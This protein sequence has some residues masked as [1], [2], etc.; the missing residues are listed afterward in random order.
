LGTKA[1]RQCSIDW[2][3]L[4]YTP[5]DLSDLDAPF[6]SQEIRDAVFSLP[7]V[8]APGP[9]GFIGAFFKSC[10]EIIKADITA[11][12][13]HMSHLREGCVGLVN[14]ANIILIPKKTDAS[15]VGDFRPISLI[16]S[17]SKIFSKLLANR[18]A[19]ILPDIVSKCQS[20]FVKK[21][22]IHDNFLHV[23]NL[24]KELHSSRTPCLFLKLDISK[25][26]DSVG[27]AYLLEVLTALGFGQAWRDWICLSLAS[28]TSRVLLNGDAGRPFCHKRGLRQGD[29]LSPMLFILAIDPLQRILS[30]ATLHGI[31]SP[32]RSRI[33]RCRISLYAD[34]AGI[35]VNPLKEELQAISS[36]LNCF[37]QASGLITNMTKTEVFPVRC[38]EVDLPDILA[39]F[40]AKIASFPGK[41]LG[42]PL[43][44]RRLRKVDLQPLIDKIA[45]KLP[46]WMGKN[47]A[48]PGRV[49]LARSVLFATGIYHAT[50]IP[51]SKWARDKINRIARTSSGLGMRVNTLHKERRLSTGRLFVGLEV[52]E[53]WGCLI[54]RE[55]AGPCDYVGLG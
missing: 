8:K 22:S 26:F 52:W 19:P 20:A 43:H 54:L 41:Y 49:T 5:H 23:Q 35:F 39:D 46:G 29:P 6:S 13:V 55:R 18:L 14:S 42:L 34:D 47:I 44:F 15:S 40:P 48:R 32:I 3:S 7:S 25:A 27:W 37:G 16:H 31:L 33:T 24:I 30:K 9:D 21:R 11:A 10:W 38:D 2:E 53:A 17:L 51:L 45:G 50:A 12:I 4:D 1:P 28:A 36:I